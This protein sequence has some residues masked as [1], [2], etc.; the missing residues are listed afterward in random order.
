MPIRVETPCLRDRIFAGW[1]TTEL[2][3][4]CGELRQRLVEIG[5]ETIIGNLEYRRL[6]V[7]VDSHD[8]LRVLHAGKMLNRAGYADRY[9]Q[10]GRHNLAGLTYLPVVGSISRIDGGA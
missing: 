2:A 5:N 3:K 7:L 1:S 8:D 6:F 9:V 10:L 4:L